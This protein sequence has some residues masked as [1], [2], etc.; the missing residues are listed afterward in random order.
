MTLDAEAVARVLREAGFVGLRPEVLEEKL[1][2]SRSTLNR[3]LR[4]LKA[5]GSIKAI[6]NGPIVRY[7]AV[8]A[9]SV[10][11]VRRYFETG[12]QS[13]PLVGF[14]ETLLQA[15]PGLDPEIANRLCRI[16]VLARQLDRRFLADLLIDLSQSSSFLE[17][18]TYSAL[19]TQALIEYGERALDKPPED[20]VLVLDHANAVRHLWEHRQLTPENICTL[21]AFLTDSHGVSGTAESDHFLPDNQRGVVREYEEV[22]LG[23]SAYSP[24]FRPGT[25]YL[26][27]ALEQIVETARILPPVEAAFFLMTR[28][29]Y[30][31]AFANGNKRTARLAANIPL[32]NAGLLPIS[33]VDFRKADYVLAMAAFYELGDALVMQEVFVEGYVRSIIRSS[34]IPVAQRVTGFNVDAVAQEL[35]D[36]IHNGRVPT[37]VAKRFVETYR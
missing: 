4:E 21:H 31:Q 14:Q 18:G 28:L 10:E 16:Q 34:N 9:Y 37:G 5:M 20:G 13:R 8:A 2:V 6:G 35:L 1:G 27:S 26:W 19:D 12:W 7:A 11:D 25:G 29:P 23:R 3:R 32:L 22:H 17:G 36:Y 15:T 24:P 30:L 33:F